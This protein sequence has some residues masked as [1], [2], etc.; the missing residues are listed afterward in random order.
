M[1]TKAAQLWWGSQEGGKK[2]HWKAWTKMAT[3]KEEGG[4]GFHN[5]QDFNMVLLAKQLWRLITQP[6]L[7]MSKVLKAKYYPSGGILNAVEKNQSS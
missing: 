1:K 4:L 6:N 2:I 3:D 5:L 7:M